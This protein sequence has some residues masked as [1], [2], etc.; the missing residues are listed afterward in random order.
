EQA[1]Q[2]IHILPGAEDA[3]ALA[4]SLQDN[5]G[6]AARKMGVEA[7]EIES[8]LHLVNDTQGDVVLIFGGELSAEAQAVFAQAPHS[9]GEREGRRIFFHPLPLFNNSVG[10]HDLGLMSGALNPLELLDAAGSEVRAMYVAGSFLPA[11]LEGREDALSKLDFLVVQELFPTATTEQADVVLPAASFAEVDGTFTNSGGL[12][13]RVRQSIPPVHQSKPDWVITS[14]IAAAMGADFGYQMASSAVF[15]D[16]ARNVAPYQG[17]RYP[18]LKDESNPRQAAHPLAGRRDVSRQLEDLRAAVDELAEG[19]EK[20]TGTPP[21]GHELFRIG[22]LTGKV[23][24]FHLL[25][26]G[27]PEPESVL[28]SPLYQITV[29][30]PLRRGEAVAGD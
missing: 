26:A 15:L 17:L 2:F 29:D 3:A 13:Q 7:A 12:V 10:C 28:I 6:L 9:F 4:F 5:A 23:P 8:A 27:N 19:G 1:A 30:P 22:T 11:H 24:Q 16:M 25:A 20:I 18:L 21:V 14:S